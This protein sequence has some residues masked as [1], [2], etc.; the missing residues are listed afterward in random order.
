MASAISLRLARRFENAVSVRRDPAQL[1][2]MLTLVCFA[3]LA[4]FLLAP[5]LLL[6][7]AALAKG[8]AVY[9]HALAN[10]ETWSAERL[11]L[12]T[13][14]I[15]V[16]LNL[17]F[18][19]AAAWAVARFE[20]SGK[21]LLLTILDIPYSV[22][23]VISGMTFVL[24]FGAQTALGNWLL[25][26]G[27]QIIFALPG[28]VLATAFVTV[29]YIARELIPTMQSLGSEEEEAALTLGA[30][31][32][33]MFTRVT[34]PNIKWSILYGVI[35]CNARAMGEFGAVSVVSGHIRGLTNTLPL[36]VEALYDDY[37][38][39]AAFAV[40]TVLMALA[41]VTLIAKS[42]VEWKSETALK[43]ALAEPYPGMIPSRKLRGLLV[44]D[45]I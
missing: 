6:A 11:T 7:N 34:L 14:G 8:A 9:L 44:G 32:W 3:F 26:H 38:A 4:L 31:G 12:I 13:A 29:P 16:P 43:G 1:R 2:W 39:T 28:L 35:L 20:F 27:V 19:L 24:I 10:E 42:V 15:S 21:K 41:V 40:S 45:K 22:S 33:Q 36:L 18:G 30:N 37:Q 23:P 25:D 17:V 5:L